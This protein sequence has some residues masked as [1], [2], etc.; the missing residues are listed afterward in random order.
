MFVSAKIGR[1]TPELANGVLQ[2]RQASV[3]AW[4]AGFRLVINDGK[5]GTVTQDMPTSRKWGLSYS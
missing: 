4:R 1:E 5:H 2:S 3:S